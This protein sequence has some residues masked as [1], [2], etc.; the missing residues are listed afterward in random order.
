MSSKLQ[1]ALENLRP[2]YKSPSRLPGDKKKNV[3]PQNKR[4]YTTTNRISAAHYVL[5]MKIRYTRYQV[6]KE[7]RRHEHVRYVR[8]R[9]VAMLQVEATST[10]H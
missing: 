2:F 4:N 5:S 9:F 7:H 10:G 6:Q 3:S 8:V 1:R